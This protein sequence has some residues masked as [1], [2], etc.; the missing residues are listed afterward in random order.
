MFIGFAAMLF[1]LLGFFGFWGGVKFYAHRFE[2]IHRRTLE[3]SREYDAA[4][5]ESAAVKRVCDGLNKDRVA[6]S[7]DIALLTQQRDLLTTQLEKR[8]EQREVLEQ[9]VAS[10]SDQ[11]K[12]ADLRVEVEGLYSKRGNLTLELQ[13]LKKKAAEAESA[14]RT[15]DDEYIR[16]K[17]IRM[18]KLAAELVEHKRAVQN[19]IND[20]LARFKELKMTETKATVDSSKIAAVRTIQKWWSSEKKN[21]EELFQEEYNR[22]RDEQREKLKK[23]AAIEFLRF[24]Q[25]FAASGMGGADEASESA[26]SKKNLKR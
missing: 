14:L 22:M 5:K 24:E 10:L 7:E 12:A 23:E 16:E 6:L 17:Q 15:V 25:I 9:E 1:L 26:S 21:L 2:T 11:Q 20:D 18:D 8:K 3:A 4:R 19:Q 13:S